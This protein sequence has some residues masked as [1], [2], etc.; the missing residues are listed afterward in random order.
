MWE[1]CVECSKICVHYLSRNAIL[2]KD[3]RRKRRPAHQ[4]RQHD[5]LEF[6]GQ[7]VRINSTR[8]VFIASEH[9]DNDTVDANGC[10]ECDFQR[11][12]DTTGAATLC[13]LLTMPRSD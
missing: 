3:K 10:P 13:S 2:L 12:N 1:R 7:Q 4:F 9:W 8:T 5:L 11:M 6:L